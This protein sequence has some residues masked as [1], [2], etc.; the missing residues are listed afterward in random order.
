MNITI[1]KTE[2]NEMFIKCI[3]KIKTY[4]EFLEFKEK[5]RPALK[6]VNQDSSKILFIFFINSYPIN[7]Y[8]IGYL[9]KLKEN[10]FIDVKIYTNDMKLFNLFKI[11]ELI[12]KF[13]ISIK[14]SE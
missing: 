14:Q 4:D 10:D 6:E 5:I 1:S 9:L 3:G 7:S 12:E 8:T 2:K 11:L 13:E